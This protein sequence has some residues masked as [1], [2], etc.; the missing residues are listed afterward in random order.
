MQVTELLE[1]VGKVEEKVVAIDY[2]SDNNTWANTYFKADYNKFIDAYTSETKQLVKEYN[3]FK[4]RF[5]GCKVPEQSQAELQQIQKMLK[6]GQAAYRDE[7]IREGKA[8]LT[9]SVQYAFRKGWGDYPMY[10]TFLK[11]LTEDM[12]RLYK[13]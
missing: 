6:F 11:N 4:R 5:D 13:K 8:Q 7:T 3:E 1:N 9:E 12:A 10:I 2:T